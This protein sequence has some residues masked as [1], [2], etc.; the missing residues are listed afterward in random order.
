[1]ATDSDP[2]FDVSPNAVR[3]AWQ[4]MRQKAGIKD[5]RFHDLRDDPYELNN[6]IGTGEQNDVAEQLAQRVRDHH[7]R[8]PWFEPE[9]K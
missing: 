4:R 8:T 6:L 3:L 2:V 9:S 1:V 5:L 7:A